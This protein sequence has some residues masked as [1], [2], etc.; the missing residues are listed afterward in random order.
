MSKHAATSIVRAN[1][2][3]ACD[4]AE[5]EEAR[6]GRRGENRTG[7]DEEMG[8]TRQKLSRVHMRVM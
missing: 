3:G 7:E 8:G 4:W 1:D 6:E 5:S 2:K